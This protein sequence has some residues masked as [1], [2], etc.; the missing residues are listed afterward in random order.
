MSTADRILIVEDE[1]LIRMT[2]RELLEAEGFRVA[3]ADT[4][5]AGLEYLR[6]AEV[7]LVLLDYKLPDI[8]GIEVLRQIR[9]L[10]P[11]TA[12]VLV[13]AHSSIGSAV[14]AIKLGAF[15]Y[16]D[17]PIDQ[18]HLLATIAKALETTR[19]RREQ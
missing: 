14:E 15:D 12:I 4:G 7:D 11:E 19:L 10:S 13:T 2:L 8:D 17:K 18:D 6:T 3:E 1:R 5:T 9:P 16:L